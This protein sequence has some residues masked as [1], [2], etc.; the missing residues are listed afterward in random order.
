MG[1]QPGRRI[2]LRDENLMASFRAALP[3]LTEADIAGSP[4]CVRN[5]VV[6]PGGHVLSAAAAV[7]RANG[8][9]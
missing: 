1:T 8:E 3:D 7:A 9:P 5:Y 6:D 2:A 4:Y